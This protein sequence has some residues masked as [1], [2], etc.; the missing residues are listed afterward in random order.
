MPR[1]FREIRPA[2]PPTLGRGGGARGW[3]NIKLSSPAGR[4]PEI[5]PGPTSG[6]VDQANLARKRVLTPFPSPGEPGL[7]CSLTL[8]GCSFNGAALFQSG[9]PVPSRAPSSPD[10]AS[11]GPLFFRAENELVRLLCAKTQIASMGPLFFRAENVPESVNVV[12][13]SAASM[14]PLFFRAE[15]CAPME[16]PQCGESLQWGRSFSERRTGTIPRAIVARRCFNGAALFQ[17]GEPV[18]RNPASMGPNASMGPLFFRAE[19]LISG[20]T[21]NGEVMLQ[22]GRSFSERRTASR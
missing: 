17:S 15:N 2:K 19:N 16:F 3:G 8:S 20:T 10:G 11:M 12:A 4:P 7:E 9:E 13:Q 14:G 18:N 5:S 1:I 21:T 6:P 22:W